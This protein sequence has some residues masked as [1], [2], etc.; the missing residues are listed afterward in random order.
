[1]LF[2]RSK[3]SACTLITALLVAACTQPSQVST[4]Q[5]GSAQTSKPI[6]A[7]RTES[8][9]PGTTAAH[10]TSQALELLNLGQEEA[11]NTALMQ[12]L[13]LDPKNKLAISLKRQISEDP[14][15]RFGK[16]SFNYVVKKG[17][18]LSQIAGRFLDDAFLFPILAR[19]NDIK[20]PRNVGEGQTLR[21]PA[22]SSQE[23]SATQ[24]TD[25]AKARADAAVA[26][27]PAPAKTSPT[28]APELK[29]VDIA[30]QA[31]ETAEKAGNLPK[32]FINYK[33]AAGLGHPGAASKL[34]EVKKK[35]LDGYARA[36]RSAL[37]RQ[38]LDAALTAW[39]KVLEL[40]PGDETALLERQKLLRLK[41]A[42][43]K[44]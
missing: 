38:D 1:M 4:A 12:A 15:A 19:Y 27:K 26:V 40:K 41:A 17:D 9:S 39:D 6:E 22:K 5:E 10:L 37:A 11:A 3:T 18:S 31:A 24:D 2:A 44:K 14:V 32:A 43:Q 21:I 7:V 29:P 33:S 13:T 16:E 30:L 20:V 25:P 23:L 28:S 42:L 35:L 34:E 36:G 8:E